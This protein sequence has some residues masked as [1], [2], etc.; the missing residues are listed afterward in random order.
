MAPCGHLAYCIPCYN[1]I[2]ESLNQP[3]TTQPPDQMTPSTECK[4]KVLKCPICSIDVANVIK[5]KN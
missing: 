4:E 1:K 5:L 3:P 2:E